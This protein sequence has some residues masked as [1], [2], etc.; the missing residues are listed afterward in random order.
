M[1]VS[2]AT[3]V[4]VLC[5]GALLW[6]LSLRLKDVSIIDIFWGPG[7]AAMVD[8][9]AWM[10]P[11]I[12]NRAFLAL[13][14]VNAWALRLAL[15][16]GLRHRGEDRRYAAMRQKFGPHWWWWSFFQIFL[17]QVIL[18]W[19]L[20]APLQAAILSG[21]LLGPLDLIGAGLALTGLL[22]E[23]VADAQ[24]ARFQ[25]NPVH[26][27][28]VL[29]SGLWRLSRH[30][31]YF[32]ETL[33]WWGFFLIGFSASGNWWLLLSPLVMTLLLLKISG[34]SLMED[35]VEDRR[36]AYAAY[37]RRV[38]AFVPWFPRQTP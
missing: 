31:N 3:L 19:L 33:L 25:K 18:I 8:I 36:P 6:L 16:I 20:P 24:L 37:K 4:F 26:K 17:L 34:I 15:H 35:G 14:L 22:F 21:I 29:D 5:C 23:A 2:L 9:A 12:N 10:A 1:T 28:R 11:Q 27:G 38:S 30:P 32:G 7:I 13:I